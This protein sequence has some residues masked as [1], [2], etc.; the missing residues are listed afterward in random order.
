MPTVLATE[1]QT[2]VPVSGDDYTSASTRI[3]TEDDEVFGHGVDTGTDEIPPAQT[4]NKGLL[5]FGLV[6]VIVG[7]IIIIL[8]IRRKN[9]SE[10]E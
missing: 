6:G 1:V 9:E 3:E 2:V 7:I 10:N 8:V 5:L 4:G